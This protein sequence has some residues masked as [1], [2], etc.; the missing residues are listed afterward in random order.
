MG[1]YLVRRFLT[2]FIVLWAVAT[3][4]YLLVHI[5]PGDAAELIII[6]TYGPEAVSPENL[7]AVSQ[8]FDLDRPFIVQYGDWLVG[9]FTGNLGI[10]YKYNAPVADMLAARLPNT[11]Y[12]GVISLLI[13]IVLG[14]PFGIISAIHRNGVIDHITRLVTLFLSSFPGFW[15]GL[16]LVVVFAIQLKM[17]PTSGMNRV[18]SVVLPA[19]TLSIGTTASIT[20]MMR[21]SMLD[22]L[23]QEYITVARAKGLARRR[24]VFTHALRNALPPIITVIALS[25]GHIL[26][27]AVVIETIFAWPGVGDLFNNA[28]LAK[29]IPMMEGCV[30][31]I[32]FG[33][34]FANLV[35][36]IVYACIDPRVKRGLQSS[37]AAA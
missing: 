10:S 21:T 14:I 35:A 5:S 16:M 22:V 7:Q 11:V 31:L 2:I 20:R 23:G 17:F 29:D 3:L 13:S 15:V 1:K 34:A 24:I 26:G 37:A 19:I 4:T 25:V 9:V 32:A 6:Q 8:K 30:L 12:L 27:G 28:V 18:D 33:Y 36:D